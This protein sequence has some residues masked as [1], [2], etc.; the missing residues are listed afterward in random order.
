MNS[1]SLKRCETTQLLSDRSCLRIHFKFVLGQFS[2]DSRNVRRLPCKYIP[3]VLQEPDERAFL[4]VIE[5]GA[6]DYS[7][8]FIRESQ[9]NPFS[10]SNRLHIG[11]SLNFVR[12]DHE[13]FILHSVVGLCGEGY[14]GP[15]SESH[16]N[17]AL[18]AF[19]GTLE[20]NVH[21]DN[22]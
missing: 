13:I 3:I 21:C 19:H 10:F 11:R 17:G 18:K 2:R 20:V 5:A 8:A 22:P 9:I 6:D 7:L 1:F 14:R 16:L 4:F 15:G 12:G